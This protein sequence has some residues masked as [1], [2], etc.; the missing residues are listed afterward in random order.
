M[1]GYVI[2]GRERRGFPEYRGE[3]SVGLGEGVVNLGRAAVREDAGHQAPGSQEA[4]AK[5]RRTF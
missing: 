4:N 2:G 1:N 5:S 3:G